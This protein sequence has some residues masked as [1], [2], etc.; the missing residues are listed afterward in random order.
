MGR[1]QLSVGAS[2]LAFFTSPTLL[3]SGRRCDVILKKRIQFKTGQQSQH[4]ENRHFF[5]GAKDKTAVRISDGSHF[6]GL[7]P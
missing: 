7:R 3:P 2:G 6:A 4:T 1:E 5:P